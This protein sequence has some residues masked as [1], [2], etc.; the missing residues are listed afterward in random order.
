MEEIFKSYKKTGDFHHAHLIVGN[1]EGIRTTLFDF[2]E[3]YLKH[4]TRGNPDFWHGDFDSF[5]IA[6]A[7]ALREMQAT[8]PIAS[9]RKI[10]VLETRAMTAEA[11]NAL[12]KMFEEPAKGVHFFIIAPSAEIFLPTLK[13]RLVIVKEAARQN[14]PLESKNFAL[15]FLQLNPAERLAF[16]VPII[17]A[18]DKMAAI[19]LVESVIESF[20]SKK[21]KRDAKKIRE[22]LALRSY[23]ND[24][25]A[26]IK[27]ILEHLAVVL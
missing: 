25:S 16:I 3:S 24:K 8:R 5:A 12:L 1:G 9:E 20:A 18:K 11:Q 21:T 7:R 19:S 4:A 27:L 26:S 14:F 15:P 22:L 6:D 23:L 10:F 13:S 17:E 2:I